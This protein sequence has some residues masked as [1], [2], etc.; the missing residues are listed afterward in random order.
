MPCSVFEGAYVVYTPHT[1]IVGF[2]GRVQGVRDFPYV[3]GP[4][5]RDIVREGRRR[6]RRI[7]TGFQART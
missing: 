6:G 5:G 3:W 1:S 2:R 7:Q 4:H